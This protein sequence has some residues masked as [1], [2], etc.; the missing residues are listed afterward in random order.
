MRK[1]VVSLLAAALVPLSAAPA[2][3]APLPGPVAVSESPAPPAGV[4]RVLAHLRRSL[5]SRPALTPEQERIYRNR[6]HHFRQL[7]IL[8]GGHR[9]PRPLL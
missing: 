8:S 3:A 7:K 4:V 1:L 2:A 6:V 5:D 9:A